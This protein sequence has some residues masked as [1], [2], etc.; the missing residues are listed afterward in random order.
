MSYTALNHPKWMKTP[1]PWFIRGKNILLNRTIEE[2]INNDK[3][4]NVV[5]FINFSKENVMY[6]TLNKDK[7][8]VCIA[9]CTKGNEYDK[10]S[11][12]WN[13]YGEM[14]D[15]VIPVSVGNNVDIS[16]EIKEAI[17]RKY[18]INVSTFDWC[19]NEY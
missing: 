18:G 3:S 5:A 2:V 14:F 15:A 6:S 1:A 10:V 12:V 17:K 4:D 7:K 8:F 16:T 11:R 9:L 13:M 19:T